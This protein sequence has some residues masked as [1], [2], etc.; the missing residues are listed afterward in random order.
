MTQLEIKYKKINEL[1]AYAK[2]SRTHSDSQIEQLVASLKEF[3]FTNPILIDDKNGIVAGHGRIK[4]AQVLGMETVPTI[5]LGD[6][7]DE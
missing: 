2:N 7:T 3:G 1:T 5:K 4:A 6:L